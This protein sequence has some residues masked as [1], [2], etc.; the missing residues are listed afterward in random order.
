[1]TLAR[2]A[3]K[4]QFAASPDTNDPKDHFNRHVTLDGLM[5]A[6][7]GAEEDPTNGFTDGG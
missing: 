7:G 1:L 4:V 6:P 3:T 2:P 5:R